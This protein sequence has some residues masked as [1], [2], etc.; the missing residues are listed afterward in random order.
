MSNTN[1][2]NPKLYTLNAIAVGTFLGGPL[3]GGVMVRRN[4]LHLG[5]PSGASLPLAIAG[6]ATVLMLL[7]L[8]MLPSGTAENFPKSFL[9]AIYL[10]WI[11]HWSRKAMGPELERR[12]EAGAAFYS[13]WRTFGVGVASMAVTFGLAGA[14][15]ALAPQSSNDAAYQRGWER[16]V[17]NETRA[18]GLSTLASQEGTTEQDMVNF[19]DQTYQPAWD[20]S[21]QA[22]TE[23]ESLK[24][25]DKSMTAQRTELRKYVTLQQ[26]RGKLLRQ[27]FTTGDEAASKALDKVNADLEKIDLNAK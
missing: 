13:G 11:V 15:F 25:L 23:M 1:I 12:K 10:G 20:D 26:K 21:E 16:V 14:V 22:V 5:R 8:A 18:Q 19:I 4:L 27:V 9:P 6:A 24:M 3:A 17:A 2:H 7:F